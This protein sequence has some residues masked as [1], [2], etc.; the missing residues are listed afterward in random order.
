[1]KYVKIVR[2]I[3]RILALLALLI[4]SRVVYF[5][6]DFSQDTIFILILIV[7]LLSFAHGFFEGAIHEA[8]DRNK[9]PGTPGS[10]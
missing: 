3:F 7:G 4:V 9:H 1:M 6:K 5:Q 8:K 2:T 10:V